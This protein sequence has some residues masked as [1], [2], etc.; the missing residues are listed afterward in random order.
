MKLFLLIIAFFT[1]FLTTLAQD[2]IYRTN[3]TQIKCKV[4]REDSTNVHFEVYRNQ[5]KHSTSLPQSE[6]AKIKYN[7]PV[8]KT[9]SDSIV[10]VKALIGHTYYYQGE[11]ISY[12]ELN[13]ILAT[14][15]V[16]RQQSLEAQPIY[17][18]SQI[19]SGVGGFCVGWELGSI[20]TGTSSGGVLLLFGAGLIGI[21]LPIYSRYCK[22]IEQALDIYNSSK[23]TAKIEKPQNLH[24]GLNSSGISFSLHF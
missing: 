1:F 14:N 19:I 16:S 10:A 20:V 12:S 21:S 11:R 5:I 18:L 17:V 24:V 13:E 2:I 7:C 9:F 22:K 8:P 15:P 3:G 23:R 6:V 4:T